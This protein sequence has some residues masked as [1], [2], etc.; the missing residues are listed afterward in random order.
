MLGKVSVLRKLDKVSTPEF[1]DGA[2]CA[3]CIECEQTVQTAQTA[4][5]AQAPRGSATYATARQR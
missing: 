5:V 3:K 1:T 4:Q 2:N